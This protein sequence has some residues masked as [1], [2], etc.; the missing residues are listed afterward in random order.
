[1]NKFLKKPTIDRRHFLRGLGVSL[2][3]PAFES[4]NTGFA[5]AAEPTRTKRLL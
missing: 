3:L 2:A 5:T 4:L 1:M